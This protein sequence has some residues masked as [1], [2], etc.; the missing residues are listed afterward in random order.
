MVQ[1]FKQRPPKITT[2]IL[3]VTFLLFFYFA[4]QAQVF[5]SRNPQYL[6]KKTEQDNLTA[7]FQQA[8]PDTTVTH[9]NNFFPRNFMGNVALPSPEYFFSYGTEPLGFRFLN[10]PITNDRIKDAQVEYFRSKGP[11]ADLSAMGGSK[12]MQAFKMIFTHT[13]KEKVNIT[14]R[15]NRYS[16]QGF[17][18]KQQTYANNFFM[19]SNYTAKN[20][21][22]GYYAYVLNNGNKNQENGGIEAVMLTDST[23]NMN[24]ALFPVKLNGA[25][26]DNRETKLMIN[27]WLRL[28]KA[29]D[30]TASTGHFLQLK[31]RGSLSA[32]KY[33]DT[34]IIDDQYYRLIYLD[35]VSTLDS[36]HVKQLS[37]E[38]DY[39]LI[40]ADDKFGFS[41]GYKNEI[42]QVWQHS[43]NRFHNHILV[44]NAVYR[45]A[46]LKSDST[47]VSQQSLESAFRLEY[48]LEGFNSGNYKLESNSLYNFNS[49]KRRNVFLN[50]LYEKRSVDRIY[51]NWTSNHFIWADNGYSAQEQLQAKAGI[52][53]GRVF[54]ASVLF[55][56]IYNYLYF[57]ELALPRQYTKTINNTAFTL[58]YSD[59]FFK[60]L[61][62]VLNYTYQGTSNSYLVRVPKNSGT[63]KL[64]YTGNLFKNNLQL[65]IGSQLQVYQEFYAYDYMPATQVFYLQNSFQTAVYPFVDV[66]LNA[67]I[68]P[69]SFFLKMENALSGLAGNNYAFVPGYYQPP[70]AFRFGLSWVFFD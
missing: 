1:L 52:N 53:F 8:Y 16:S 38:L 40:S 20:K 47:T 30:S 62:L 56:N 10:P 68:R 48:V 13:Y 9:L 39:T 61:G 43:G 25:N 31:S 49:Q 32:Y 12:L 2:R 34:R 36:S 19:S 5:I 60:H 70:R 45:S 11:Y 24:K 54:S 15:F 7:A 65:Q 4:S 14:L 21:R 37:N 41:A 69:V 59:V 35:T 55:Q 67:R 66:F 3:C 26:R 50:L 18:L 22:F 29:K 17:Y 28:N 57:D 33:K 42:T 58:N 27:P 23:V 6:K 51:N 46:I 44:S 63:A 64:F